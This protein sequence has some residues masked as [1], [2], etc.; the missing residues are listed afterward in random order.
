MQEWSGSVQVAVDVI[1]GATL[2]VAALGCWYAW[3][4]LI[5]FVDQQRA[6]TLDVRDY[7]I[8]RMWDD[9]ECYPQDIVS[10]VLEH[11][12]APAVNVT[13]SSGSVLTWDTEAHSTVI[14]A[15]AISAVLNANAMYDCDVVYD[16]NG[17]LASFNFREV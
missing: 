10:L 13:T 16:A 11:Q 2:I 15:A 8:A 9:S 1:I 12:G 14:S 3:N 5:N 6:Y 4:T 17:S 7:R